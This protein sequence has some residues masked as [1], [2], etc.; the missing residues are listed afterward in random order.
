M[1][2]FLFFILGILLLNREKLNGQAVLHNGG[3]MS[4]V[5]KIDSLYKYYGV[6]FDSSY[7][8]PIEIRNIKKRITPTESDVI[9]A[10]EIF[11]AQYNIAN[12]VGEG[13]K[14]GVL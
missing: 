8:P 5:I 1:K 2:I 7:T 11:V 4:Q 9:V 14:G 13:R 10:E 3:S 6:I 12:Q